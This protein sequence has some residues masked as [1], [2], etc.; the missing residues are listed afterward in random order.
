MITL[1]QFTTL[2]PVCVQPQPVRMREKRIGIPNPNGTIKERALQKSN[3]ILPKTIRNFGFHEF[4]QGKAI[5]AGPLRLEEA[6]TV[7]VVHDV[8]NRLLSKS[9]IA[10]LGGHR[11]SGGTINPRKGK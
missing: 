3:S 9:R 5:A 8:R 6:G 10:R 1:G 2:P 4:H 11:R 7:T